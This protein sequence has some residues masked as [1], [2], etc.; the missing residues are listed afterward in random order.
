M[1]TTRTS[2]RCE[3]GA[4][5]VQA[6]GDWADVIII[7]D[8]LRFTL[9]VSLGVNWGARVVPWPEPR[10]PSQAEAAAQGAV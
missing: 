3:W 9:L 8:A 4:A 10:W 5:G 1:T 6:H 2:I 7:I